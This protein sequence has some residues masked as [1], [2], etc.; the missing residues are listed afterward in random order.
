MLIFEFMK[1]NFRIFLKEIPC[2][3]GKNLFFIILKWFLYIAVSFRNILKN[4]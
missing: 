2:D 4:N 3:D 1:L